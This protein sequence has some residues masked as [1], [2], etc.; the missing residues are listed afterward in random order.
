[1]HRD[2]AARNALIDLL[3]GGSTFRAKLSD[4]GLSAHVKYPDTPDEVP[5]AIWAPECIAATPKQ[6]YAFACDV[7]A[8]GLMLVEAV[9]GVA[10]SE[11]GDTNHMVLLAAS[12][13][14][15]LDLVDVVESFV[16]SVVSSEAVPVVYVDEGAR[17]MAAFERSAQQT[18]QLEIARAS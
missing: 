14:A 6:P 3:A 17:Q 7:W 15:Q 10:V 9:N 2:V 11:G 5:I 13:G 18:F 1:M 12:Q 16:S 4:F 8:F